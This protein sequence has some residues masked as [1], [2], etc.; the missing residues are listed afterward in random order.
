V[1]LE[2]EEIIEPP[3][4]NVKQ[5][6]QSEIEPK[7]L[8]KLYNILGLTVKHANSR[9]KPETQKWSLP[10]FL[11]YKSYHYLRTSFTATLETSF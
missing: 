2:L 5:L 9:M 10:C 8:L 7:E 4:L 6:K 1:F 11:I 3:K